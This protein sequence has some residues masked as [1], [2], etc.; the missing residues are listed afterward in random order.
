[1]DNYLSAYVPLPADKDELIG[2][3]ADILINEG[4][5]LPEFAREVNDRRAERD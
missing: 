3:L 5:D 2:L 4:I 1:M